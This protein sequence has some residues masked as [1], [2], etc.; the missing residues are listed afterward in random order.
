[1]RIL[2]TFTGSFALGIFLAQYLVP[3]KWLL[4]CGA[5]AFVLAFGRLFLRNDWGRRVLLM[6]VGLALAFGYDWLYIRQI[7]RPMEALAGTDR[8]VVMTLCDYAVPTNYGAK[9]TVR[10][11]GLSG[12]AVYY[13]TADLLEMEPGQTV[14]DMVYLQ[15][16]SR[17]RDDDVTSF[18]SKGVFLLAYCR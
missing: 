7:Q 1:M 14:T 4:P 2:A 6:G 18:T 9:A 12:K 17:I 10:L 8:E 11:E 5:A 13:G 15:S 3:A 16:A